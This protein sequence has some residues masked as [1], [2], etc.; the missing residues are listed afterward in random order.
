VT[1]VVR[2][3]LYAPRGLFV[4]AFAVVLAGLAVHWGDWPAM[5]IIGIYLGWLLFEVP[6]TFRGAVPLK[7]FR[8]LLPY[9]IARI[10]TA[11]AAVLVPSAW[12]DSSDGSLL[13]LVP[14]AV[15]F[16]GGIVL[17][18]VA[19]RTL[20]RFY[21]HHVALRTD[22]VAVN[23]GP[24]RRIRHP[25]YAGMLLAHTGLVVFFVNPAGLVCLISLFATVLWRIRVE[26]PVL[27]KMP[28][29]P[30]YAT[31]RMRLI[32]GVW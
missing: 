10:A 11:G 27:W 20:G 5:V 12:A 9:A 26:E 16:A 23:T 18:E 1:G 21:S 30:E 4:I 32:P 8:T 25:A 7:D 19:I 3:L 17:R 6:V 2:L 31:G 28:G 29:Y 14:A 22:Q 15:L 24:Y 13:L